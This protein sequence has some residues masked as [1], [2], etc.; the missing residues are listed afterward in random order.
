[1]NVG[2]H[3]YDLIAAL[4]QS[5]VTSVSGRVGH[6]RSDAGVE[7]L[8]A[9]SLGTSSGQIASVTTGYLYPT[10][11][12]DQRE[13]SFS[14]AHESAYLQGYGRMFSIKRPGE[15]AARN[16]QVEYNTDVFYPPFLSDALARVREGRQPLVGLAEA[17]RA[18]AVVEAGYRSA[19]HGG[20]AQAV[21]AP[22]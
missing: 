13:F 7:E 5:A 14:V 3:F 17:E 21:D 6:F 4:T 9:F 20:S 12:E 15:R 1:M 19:A 11:A 16:A 2:V 8:A 22:Q 10:S 18:I